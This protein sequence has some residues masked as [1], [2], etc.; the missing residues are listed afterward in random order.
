MDAKSLPAHSG[1][2]QN[3]KKKKKKK[4]LQSVVTALDDLEAHIY[5]FQSCISLSQWLPT[6]RELLWP[7]KI[8]QN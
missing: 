4:I 7:L 3:G 8:E 6:L 5:V 1:L 2:K